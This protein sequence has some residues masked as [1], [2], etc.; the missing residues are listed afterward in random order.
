[1]ISFNNEQIFIVTGAS[2]GI[3]KATALLLNEL[4]AS[5]IA[6]AR[7]ELRLNEL[8]QS[9]KS[10]QN[11]FIE[12][13]DLTKDIENL[14]E[15]VRSLKNKYGKFSGLA[16][17]A[18]T[19]NVIPL[20]AIEYTKLSEI[21]SIDYFS[22]IFMV[23]GFSDKRNYVEGYAS[24][25]IVSSCSAI[26]SDKGHLAYAGAKAALNASMKVIA[27][28]VASSGLRVNCVSPTTIDTPL[29]DK[30]EALLER[31]EFYPLGVGKADDVA[32]TIVFLL[33]GKSKWITGQ[34]YI[35][36]CASF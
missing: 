2:S 13:K 6:I 21:F 11:L 27:K 4:G 5:V 36:D 29:S 3:G 32:T 8:K 35:I 1:M 28:E 22:P 25:V 20:R 31:N 15:Y 26:K 18:G 16:F 23:K 19:S 9:A 7:N 10:P 30:T 14:P 17:C 33:S 12:V 34:N 24:C